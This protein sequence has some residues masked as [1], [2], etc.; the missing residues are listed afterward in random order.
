MKAPQRPSAK[1]PHT[2]LDVLTQGCDVCKQFLTMAWPPMGTAASD[3]IEMEY[4]E[5]LRTHGQKGNL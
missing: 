1:P 3:S 4:E 2:L 5:H